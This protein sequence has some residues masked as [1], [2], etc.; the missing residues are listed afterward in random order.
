MFSIPPATTTSASPKA[1][2][3]AANII[4]FIPEE[5]TLLTVVH[6]TESGIP[7]NIAACLAGACPKPAE[8]T[9]PI[10]TSSTKAG[11]KFILFNAP[12]IA[13]EPNFGAGMLDK[14]P[15]KLPIGVLATDTITTSLVLIFLCFLILICSAKLTILNQIY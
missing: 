2:V 12:F 13:I 1:I 10:K 9:F 5:Q 3:W 15:I 11:S 8:T 14:L 7:A 4:D 6:G